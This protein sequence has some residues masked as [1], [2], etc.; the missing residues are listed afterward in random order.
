MGETDP[1]GFIEGAPGL[2][3]AERKAILGNNAARLLNL[4]V[5]AS[6]LTQ[7]GKT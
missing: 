2:D 1:V 6:P 4:E 7:G 5:P 3:D